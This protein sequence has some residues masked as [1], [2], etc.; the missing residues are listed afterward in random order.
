MKTLLLGAAALLLASV[1]GAS[2][3]EDNAFVGFKA[4]AAYDYRATEV[5]R[6][7][8][9]LPASIDERQGGSGYRAHLG[10]DI[11]LSD[12]LILGAE[13]GVGG[14]GKAVTVKSAAGDYSVKP[15]LAYDVSARLGVMPAAH[16]LL[17][18]RAGYQWV[19][20]TETVKYAAPGMA[21][22]NKE[23]REGG[24]MYG[25]GVEYAATENLILRA[26][27]DQTRFGQGLKA[28]QVQLGGAFRF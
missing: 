28:A 4:G 21:A 13:A 1:Q 26:E 12:R 8:P 17:Y 6:S 23:E 20:T 11:S 14:G 2:A 18:G 3:Q 15:G 7:V 10:Y 16:V 27:F 25:F 22:V 19:K 9:G 24:A 5:K